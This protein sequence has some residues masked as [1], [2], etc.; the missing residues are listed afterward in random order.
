M[1]ELRQ[2]C[3]QNRQQ[4][5]K[6]QQFK[7]ALLATQKLLRSNWC[8]RPKKIAL[9]LAQDGELSTELLVKPLR[10]RGHSLYLP[11]LKTLRGR[12]MA[13]APYTEQTKFI[14]NQFGILE[15]CVTQQQ[16]LTGN[17]LD[18]VLTPLT[19]FDN[20]GNRIGMGGGFYDKTF[21]FK[22]CFLHHKPKLIGWAH[23]CQ[24]VDK[25][26]PKTWDIP[27]DVLITEDRLITF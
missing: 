24:K 14:P 1:Q 3:R 9:F 21:A 5:C 11:I 22:K 10:M 20:F 23:E 19:C 2:F 12:N 26:F 15:P 25:I 8:Q 27:L 6:Q 17:Q 16:H 7:H 13:F 4:L 18:L